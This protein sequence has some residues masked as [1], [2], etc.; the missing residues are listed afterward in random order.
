MTDDDYKEAM[1]EALNTIASTLSDINLGISKLVNIGLESP[2]A[3]DIKETAGVS[4]KQIC[5]VLNAIR[6]HAKMLELAN[7]AE[8]PNSPTN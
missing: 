8:Q 6:Q 1:L 3:K 7:A 5:G 2:T 4:T